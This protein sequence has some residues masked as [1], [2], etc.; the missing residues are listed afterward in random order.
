MYDENI[1]LIE[2]LIRLQKA[3]IKLYI[4]YSILI[5]SVGICIILIGVKQLIWHGDAIIALGGVIFT[6]IS[7]FPLKELIHKKES[8]KQYKSYKMYLGVFKDNIEKQHQYS[9][10]IQ[11]NFFKL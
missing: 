10:I 6:M 5:I 7:S 3:S 4:N 2:Q 1:E 8:I 11:A 9:S